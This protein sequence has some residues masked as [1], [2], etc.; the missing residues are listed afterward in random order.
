MFFEVSWKHS[1]RMRRIFRQAYGKPRRGMGD[2]RTIPVCN[3]DA[4][5]FAA[6]VAHN[7]G[8]NYER[9]LPSQQQPPLHFGNIQ[10][11]TLPPTIYWVLFP[12]AP[13]GDLLVSRSIPCTCS[14]NEPSLNNY[15][16]NCHK[17]DVHMW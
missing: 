11:L 13:Y 15:E 9:G 5:L 10:A 8:S 14:P 6:P 1:G 2:G 4:H 17:A 16:V 7:A 12:I 3:L